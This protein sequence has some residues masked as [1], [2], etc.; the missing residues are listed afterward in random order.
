MNQISRLRIAIV[1]NTSWYAYN[2]RRNLIDALKKEGHEV[3]VLSPSDAYSEKLLSIGV[4]HCNWELDAVSRNPYREVLSILNLRR[5]IRNNRIELILS[6]TPKGNI[7]SGLACISTGCYT[8]P[9]VSGRGHLASASRFANIVIT[10][11]YRLATRRAVKVFFQNEEDLDAFVSSGVLEISRA[12]RLMGSGVDLARFNPKP[13][14]CNQDG[15]DRGVSFLFVGRLLWKKGIREYISAAEM[16]M[17]KYPRAKWHILG[18]ATNNHELGASVSDIA[19]WTRRGIIYL[20]VSDDVPKILESMDC[21]VLP[22]F[23]GEGVPRSLLEASAMGRPCITT[24]TAGCRDAVKD[25]RTGFIC[26]PK[27]AESLARRMIGF[28]SLSPESREAMGK[29]ASRFMIE[30]FDERNVI[31]RYSSVVG[32]VR[33]ASGLLKEPVSPSSEGTV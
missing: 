1:T 16:L 8:I 4:A 15:T 30:N 11:A 23:Y 3:I 18:E 17:S 31:A 5:L 10:L 22:S 28:L 24:D 2:F 9:N 32:M 25:G 27:S 19:D 7:Y 13:L 21:I 14:P 26:E 6:F 33:D 12:E 29:E 20:G